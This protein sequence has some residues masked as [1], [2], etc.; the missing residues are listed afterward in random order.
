LKRKVFETLFKDSEVAETSCTLKQT[1]H[2]AAMI[3]SLAVSNYTNFLTNDNAGMEI[4]QLPF[5]T[6]FSV[7][8]FNFKKES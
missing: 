6:S 2:V 3:A 7:S 5:K 4:R 1:T 8:D